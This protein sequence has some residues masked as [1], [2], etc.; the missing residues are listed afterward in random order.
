[1]TGGRGP[2]IPLGEGPVEDDPFASLPGSAT[3]D[4]HGHT[5]GAGQASSVTVVRARKIFSVILAKVEVN[6]KF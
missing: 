5:V 3:V 1:M 6:G 2:F 4:R